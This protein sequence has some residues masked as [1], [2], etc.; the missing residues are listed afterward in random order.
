L[1]LCTLCRTFI[2][3]VNPLIGSVISVLR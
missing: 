1:T 2:T 3:P